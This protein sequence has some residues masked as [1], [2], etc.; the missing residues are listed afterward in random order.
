[1]SPPST[2]DGVNLVMGIR[3]W[4]MILVLS[5]MW[6]GPFFFIEVAVDSVAPLTVVCCRVGLAAMI[7]L[8]I[9]RLRR[10]R[11]PSSQAKQ[12]VEDSSRSFPVRSRK[13]R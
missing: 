7:L 2:A 4:T 6:G 13:L 11:L 12:D 3:E 9:L 8:A 10:V 5:I 1:M